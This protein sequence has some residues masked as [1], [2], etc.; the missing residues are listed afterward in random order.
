MIQPLVRTLSSVALVALA[1]SASACE[2]SPMSIDGHR[3]V[4]LADLDLGG[5]APEE[6]TLLGPDTIHIVQGD[7]L[8]IRT[9]GDARDSLRFV[10]S[11]GKLGVG[12][13]NGQETGTAT[14]EV[15]VP[16]ARRL[17]LAGSGA[18]TID[19]LGGDA[20]GVTIAG[21]GRV[22]AAHVEAGNLKVD[23]LGSGTLKAAGKVDGLKLTV[24]GSGAAQMPGLAVGH[25]DVNVAGSGN[26]G[27]ASDGQVKASIMG[28]GE[29][30]VTGRAT[31]K[32]NAM[33]SGRLVC[34]P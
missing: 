15:T 20:V 11:D 14:I 13:A 19:A 32:V 9:E 7:R 25:A 29:V 4:P 28:S 34:Q 23:V 26:A 6:I 27:F 17:V 18:M 10:R 16:A 12:R 8:A 21:S 5:T 2:S 31:C 24:A 30:H 22:D 3:G 33:G 1:L